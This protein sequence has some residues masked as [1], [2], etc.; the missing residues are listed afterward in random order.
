MVAQLER[1]VEILQIEDSIADIRLTEEGLKEANF[2]SN[3][4]VVMDGEDALLYLNKEGKYQSAS[5][6][7]LILLDL[8]LPKKDGRDVLKEIKANPKLKRIPVVVFST[9][10]DENDISTSYGLHANSF[11]TKPMELDAFVDAIK[12]IE[13]FWTQVAQLPPK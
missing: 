12:S 1:P 7:D 2:N 13:T 4:N 6:P 9:S 11:V 3:V 8:N 5:T 10:E